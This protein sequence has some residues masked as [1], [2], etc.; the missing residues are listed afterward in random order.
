MSEQRTLRCPEGHQITVETWS[1]YEEG[2]KITRVEA[3]STHPHC[4]LCQD[5]L[6]ILREDPEA[7]EEQE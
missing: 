2:E 3:Y 1:E 7:F 6:L 5:I 4:E